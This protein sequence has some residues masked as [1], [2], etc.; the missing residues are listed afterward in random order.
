MTEKF[1][2]KWNDFNDN[3][4]NSFGLLKNEDYLHD[5]TLVSDDNI[6]ISAHKLVLSACSDYFKNIFKNNKNP[7]H[8][9]FLCLSGISYEDLNNLVDYMYYGEVNIYQENLDRFLDIA[10]RLKLEGLMKNVEKDSVGQVKHNFKIEE[11]YFH[12]VTPNVKKPKLPVI[13]N[14]LASF[15]EVGSKSM[16]SDDIQKINDKIEEYIARDDQ[17]IYNCTYC[18][19]IGDKYKSHIKNHIE[20]HLDGL[21]FP[22]QLCDKTFRSRNSLSL[23]IY[24]QHKY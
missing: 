14:A 20:T 11:A 22:C 7:Y 3:V 4:S 8:H 5:V 16:I 1:K 19:K 21:S 6:Q 13:T 17:G 10:Q 15:E 23:H 12:E 9:P 24:R 2:L 18:G